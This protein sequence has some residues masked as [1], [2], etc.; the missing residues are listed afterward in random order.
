MRKLPVAKVL[1]GAFY[2]P[3]VLRRSLAKSLATLVI[4]GVALATLW[5]QGK[6]AFPFYINLIS[7][8]L[9][10]LV[11]I[12][13]AVICHRMVLLGYTSVPEY[14]PKKVS[15]RELRFALGMMK[16][17]FAA[18]LGWAFFYVIIIQ[19]PSWII[20]ALH[21]GGGDS[22][23]FKDHLAWTM[24][25]VQFYLFARLSLILPSIAVDGQSELKWAWQVSK[26]NGLRLMLVLGLLPLLVQLPLYILPDIPGFPGSMINSLLWWL[27]L[28]F[29]ITAL[30]LSYKELA[31]ESA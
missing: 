21:G 3:W 28:P 16:V 29:E 1:F 9:F 8:L 31:E 7:L 6:V 12:L 18:F 13:F 2:V 11:Y 24:Y 22:G 5:V 10:G 25:L 17:M 23:R 27:M 19:F 14:G 4:G 26:G 20:D 15:G 30:S